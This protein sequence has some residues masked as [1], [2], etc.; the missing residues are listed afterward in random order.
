[1]VQE[2]GDAPSD[3]GARNP[4]HD[5]DPDLVAAQGANPADVARATAELEAMP[6]P[7][8][9]TRAGLLAEAV[10]SIDLTTLSGDDT[11]DK[12]RKLCAK[13]R[14]PLNMK[15]LD[16]LGIENLTTAAV[17]V[18]HELIATALEALEGSGIPVAAVSAGFPD[19][20]SPLAC[21]VKEVEASSAAGARE[22]DIVIRRG[23]VLEG[24][25][26]AVYDEV[27]L[28]REACGDAH[29]KAI[30]GTGNLA[31][32][33]NIAKASVACMMAGADFIKTSTG[34]EKINATPEA[35][36]VMTACIRDWY[37]RT[38]FKVGFKAAG[39]IS[40][41]QD[42]LLYRRIMETELGEE[43]LRPNLFRIG[44][45]SLLANIAA[46][47]DAFAE[48]RGGKK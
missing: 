41:P 20:L 24:N 25:L 29:L 13:A 17:C 42:A 16:A 6:P 48:K 31:T 26:K 43:W 47:L 39:G 10:A 34:K 8:G 40:M 22:I 23:H 15:T 44:A 18:Y 45:S 38:G 4:I 14:A 2:M 11:Q 46:E 27:R 5:Y 37:K 32:P 21:R 30:I 36:I 1:M 19:G 7:V 3:G 35:A 9:K 12:V 33:T 28:F